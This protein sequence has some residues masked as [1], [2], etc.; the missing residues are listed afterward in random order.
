MN[1]ILCEK[2]IEIYINSRINK[3]IIQIG[4]CKG[5]F[6]YYDES[7]RIKDNVYKFD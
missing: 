4:K 6:N 2:A 3:T 5:Y 7:N 1:E